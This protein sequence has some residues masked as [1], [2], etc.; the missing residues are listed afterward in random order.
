MCVCKI[1]GY[2]YAPMLGVNCAVLTKIIY[3]ISRRY[4]LKIIPFDIILAFKRK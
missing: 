1:D 4:L 2:I 3:N